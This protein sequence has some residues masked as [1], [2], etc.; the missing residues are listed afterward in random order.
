MKRPQGT[1]ARGI[2]H[3]VI[4]SRDRPEV[5]ERLWARF[6][7]TAGI[8]L[9]FDRRKAPKPVRVEHRTVR[10]SRSLRLLNDGFMVV[11]VEQ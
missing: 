10:A 9:I 5:F 2:S 8:I 11:P 3:L 7:D 1:P 6:T 4:V